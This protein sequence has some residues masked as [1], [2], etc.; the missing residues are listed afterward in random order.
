M[1]PEPGRVEAEAGQRGPG[2]VVTVPVS[3]AVLTRLSVNAVPSVASVTVQPVGVGEK[4]AK[5]AAWPEVVLAGIAVPLPAIANVV[6]VGV[7]IERAPAAPDSEVDC[8]P[9]KATL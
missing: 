5:S 8:V 3:W 6:G 7:V 1:V 4:R 9:E 2:R